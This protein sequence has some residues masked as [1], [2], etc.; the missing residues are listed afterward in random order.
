MPGDFTKIPTMADT[1]TSMP[2]NIPAGLHPHFQEYDVIALDFTRDANLIIQ[3]TLEFGTWEEV[4]WLFTV[5]GSKP[6]RAFVKQYGERWLRPVSFQY[7]R[8]LLRID[9]W[10]HSPF[11]TNKGELWNL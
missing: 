11:P 4:R 6:I 5:Y 7:W 8:K 1:S 10:R 2:I 3:R 9:K